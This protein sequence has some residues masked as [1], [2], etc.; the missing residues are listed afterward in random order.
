MREVVKFPSPILKS[1]CQDITSWPL[2]KDVLS[3]ISEMKTIA[4]SQSALGIAANQVGANANVFYINTRSYEGG[5]EETFVNPVIY[6][7]AGYEIKQEGCLSFGDRLC[8]VGRAK[9]VWVK[10]KDTKGKDHDVMLTGMSA[11]CAQHEIDHLLG[12][13]MN[14]REKEILGEKV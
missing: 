11:R 7:R 3:V 5:L 6:K 2:S 12:I 10:Y 9:T 13:T 4:K 1:K 8:F 14:M